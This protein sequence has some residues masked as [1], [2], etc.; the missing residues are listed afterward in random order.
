MKHAFYWSCLSVFACGF[1][2]SEWNGF[3][4]PFLS[5]HFS[6]FA[7]TGLVTTLVIGR[8]SFGRIA[9]PGVMRAAGVILAFTAIELVAD[10]PLFLYESEGMKLLGFINTADPVDALFGLVGGLTVIAFSWSASRDR[11]HSEAF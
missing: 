8:S 5:D 3:A 1:V 9:V 7:A 2:L 6:N 10:G 4:I 11:G